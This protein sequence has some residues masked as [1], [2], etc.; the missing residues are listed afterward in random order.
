[1]D[2][3]EAVSKRNFSH[4]PKLFRHCESLL[5][6]LEVVR[7]SRYD[8]A[9]G[10]PVPERR[11]PVTSLKQTKL[12]VRVNNPTVHSYALQVSL[13]RDLLNQFSTPILDCPVDTGPVYGN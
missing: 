6:P 4:N 9:T 8:Y 13:G 12:Q 7:I 11:S 3:Q 1:M 5:S 10:F 2:R